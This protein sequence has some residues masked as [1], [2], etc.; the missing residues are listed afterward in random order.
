MFNQWMIKK[1]RKTLP[2]YKLDYEKP[3]ENTPYNQI[4]GWKILI[5]ASNGA[6]DYGNKIGE[7]IIVGFTRNYGNT[8]LYKNKNENENENDKN[9][10]GEY[11][12]SFEG[13]VGHHFIV[14]NSGEHWSCDGKKID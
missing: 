7:P 3:Y 2:N 4:P 14:D 6:S 10:A 13:K 1:C 9:T 12:Q 11:P 8:I 5:E